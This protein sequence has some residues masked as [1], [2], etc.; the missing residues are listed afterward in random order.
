MDAPGDLPEHALGGQGSVGH[1]QL[2][3]TT[4]AVACSCRTTCYI[5]HTPF[6]MLH[7]AHYTL[8]TTYGILHAADYILHTTYDD[9]NDNS[10]YDYQSRHR[11]EQ[12]P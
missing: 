5:L 8:H 4:G 1:F 10:H 9:D 11:L 6:C 2:S 12:K 7:N 3:H